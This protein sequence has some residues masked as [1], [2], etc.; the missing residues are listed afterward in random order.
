MLIK[1]DYK[2]NARIFTAKK[3]KWNQFSKIYILS[4]I[5]CFHIFV[6]CH[7]FL[8]YMYIYHHIFYDHFKLFELGL[9]PS[10]K[11][12]Y[13]NHLYIIYTIKY[14][15]T[16]TF[17]YTRDIRIIFFV[18]GLKSL[19]FPAFIDSAIYWITLVFFLKATNN[20]LS[21]YKLISKYVL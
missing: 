19:N 15:Q 10:F 17:L 4:I 9:E 7:S 8:R 21:I 18:E 20:K 3:K 16:N 14:F 6:L 2:T 11:N 13:W 1:L 12:F 5:L